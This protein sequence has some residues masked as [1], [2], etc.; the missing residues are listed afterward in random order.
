[1]TLLITKYAVTAF[2]IVNS[3]VDLFYAL[4]DPRID[5]GPRR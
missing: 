2:I 4:L 3:A 5:V 1:M